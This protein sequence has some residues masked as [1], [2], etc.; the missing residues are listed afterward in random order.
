VAGGFLVAGG[1]VF[2]FL[3]RVVHIPSEFTL[4][5]GGLGLIIASIRNPEGIAGAMR[6]AG[7]RIVA[8]RRPPQAPEP[9]RAPQPEPVT[10]GGS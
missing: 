10:T 1:L 6:T 2:T 5:L 9:P 3:E 4:I 8:R 7:E